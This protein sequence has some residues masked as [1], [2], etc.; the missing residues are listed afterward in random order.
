MNT[1]HTVFQTRR[2]LQ[3]LRTLI[4]LL[5]TV[6]LVGIS[7]RPTSVVASCTNPESNVVVQTSVPMLSGTFQTVNDGPGEQTDPHS[8]CDRASYTNDDNLGTQTIRYFDFAT[9]TDHVIPG[10]GS[11]SLSDVYGGLVAFTES[12]SSGPIVALFDTATQTRTVVPGFQNSQ[13]EL[14]GNLVVYENRSFTT[15]PNESEI[16][17]YDRSTG[18]VTRLT[19]DF[20]FD[21]GPAVSPTGNAIVWEKCQTNGLGCDIYASL[22]TAPGVFTTSQ[23]TFANGEDRF[24][25]TNG[26]I[27]VY[28]SNRSGE[29]DI[30]LQ[31]LAGGSEVPLSIPGDQRDLNIVGNLISFES[32]PLG[33]NSQYDIYLYDLST[34]N[35]YRATNTPVNETLNDLTICNG[36]VR[37]VYGAPAMDFNLYSFTF[38]VPSS[39]DNDIEDLIELVESF[40][41]PQGL[42]NSLITKLQDTLAAFE[43]SDTATACVHLSSFINECQAQAGK[44]LTAEQSG[45][46]I[47]SATEIKTELGC[48]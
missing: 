35:L 33:T 40:D 10:N 30:Y 46:L 38:Q 22:Q 28:I 8:N 29:N 27:A 32:S 42:E 2:P 21:R 7:A 39:T 34:A 5:I 24:P 16:S 17:V 12:N 6:A 36:E 20:L 25:R 47:S 15:A 37:I 23:L 44:K 19:E 48:Q 4:A 9:S 3:K 14:G 11:N 13:P 1:P 45:Q 43:A 41:L 18:N 26:D 31:S